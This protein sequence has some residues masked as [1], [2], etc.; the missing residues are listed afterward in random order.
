M[1]V[2]QLVPHA[3]IATEPRNNAKPSAGHS[4]LNYTLTGGILG[5][6]N[7]HCR[8][9]RM[10]SNILKPKQAEPAY[11]MAAVP[12]ITLSLSAGHS[13]V[14]GTPLRRLIDIHN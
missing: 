4:N 9:I 13:W 2:Q 6:A 12:G 1:L 11:S 5:N 14:T 10:V 7:A 3:G 8:H